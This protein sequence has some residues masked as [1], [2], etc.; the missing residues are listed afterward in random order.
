ME[1]DLA[2]CQELFE[3]VNKSHYENDVRL[4]LILKGRISGAIRV[5]FNQTHCRDTLKMLGLL[6][7]LEANISLFILAAL[8]EESMTLELDPFDIC[9]ID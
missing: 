7:K 5:V 3:L 9:L 2:Y 1:I 8:N 4:A 6:F